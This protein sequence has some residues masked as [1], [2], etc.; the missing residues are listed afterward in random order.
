MSH[1]LAISVGPVQEFIAAARQTRDLW[2]GS[3]L[4]S[5]VSRA[6]AAE[7]GKHGKLIF[8]S[9]GHADNIA[10][11]NIVVAEVYDAAPK[12]VTSR[13]KEAARKC[14]QEV[15]RDVFD[16]YGEVIQK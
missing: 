9:D 8:P 12:D 7:V 10:I 11:A 16:E 14:W 3:R 1:L 4:L 13:A 2:F 15:A 6:V 5:D